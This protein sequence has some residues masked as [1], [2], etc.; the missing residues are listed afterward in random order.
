MF[1]FSWT[2][3]LT[4]VQEAPLAD[5]PNWFEGFLAQLGL[6]EIMLVLGLGIV[7]SLALDTVG[8]RAIGKM[9]LIVA[10]FNAVQILVQKL[11]ALAHAIK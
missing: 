10:V 7:V 4:L 6:P 9:A 3:R 1:A 2:E 11:A 5:S 8:Q